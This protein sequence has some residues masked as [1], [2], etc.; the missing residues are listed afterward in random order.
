MHHFYTDQTHRHSIFWENFCL[1]AFFVFAWGQF[2]FVLYHASFLHR[3]DTQTQ[4]FLGKLLLGGIFCFCLGAVYLRTVPCIISTQTRHT[5]TVFSGKTF[6]WGHFLFLPGGSLP[7]YCTMHHFYTDQT[8]R[9]SIFWENFCLGAFFVFAW[10]Q[11]TFVLYHASFLRIPDMQTYCSTVWENFCL[12]AFFVFAWGHFTFAGPGAKHCTLCANRVSAKYNG[13]Q[14]CSC[15]AS[16]Q[17]A[18][19]LLGRRL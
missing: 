4:Y 7:S 19:K 18:S 3:P 8:H 11:F 6:A 17:L 10:G 5:D 16:T 1:G 14:Q 9:H 15:T 13:E 12:G 2:T